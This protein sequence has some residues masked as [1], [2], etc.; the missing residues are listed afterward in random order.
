MN[1]IICPKCKINKMES[2]YK[3]CQS[4]HFKEITYKYIQKLF[5]N[6]KNLNNN[7]DDCINNSEKILQEIKTKINNEQIKNIALVSF[8]I[9]PLNANIQLIIETINNNYSF[10]V[11]I[12][13]LDNGTLNKFDIA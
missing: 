7:T 11:T 13:L 3:H 12:S 5:Y 2:K 9:E 4:C 6:I 10:N 8:Y 1:K